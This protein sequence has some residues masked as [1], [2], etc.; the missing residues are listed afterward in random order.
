MPRDLGSTA[1]PDRLVPLDVIQQPHEGAHSAGTAN[2][3]RMQAN[4]HHARLP[5]DSQAIQPIE[6][7]AAVDEE[8]LARREI[9]A[10]L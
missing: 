8:L 9:P 1:Q 7:V 10:A 6:C 5:L 4:R 3:S 2:D